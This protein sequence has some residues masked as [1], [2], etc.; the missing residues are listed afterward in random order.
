MVNRPGEALYVTDADSGETLTP[1][2]ALSTDGNSR[3]EARHG[4]GYSVFLTEKSG[5]A[6]EALQTVARDLPVKITRLRIRNS[7]SQGRSLKVHAYAEW[8]L[9]N[10][11]QRTAPFVLTSYDAE[12][13][14][15]L[16][17]NPYS[18]DYSGRTAFFASFAPPQSYSASRREF[19]GRNGSIIAPEALS[20]TKP[21]SGNTEADGD[22]AA[23]LALEFRLGA[24]ETRDIYIYLGD[25][26]NREAAVSV[27]DQVR[28]ADFEEILKSVHAYW[29]AFNG[30]VKVKSPDRAFDLMVNGWLPYQALACRINARAAF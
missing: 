23:A 16:A 12:A 5:L 8:V 19:I 18:L 28:K 14:T 4:H 29:T 7:G 1:F 2:A 9:G 30:T 3:F 26:E 17:T 27:L 15:L 11:P 13:G 6:L 25:A 21:L 24:G 20:G 10:N 22:P